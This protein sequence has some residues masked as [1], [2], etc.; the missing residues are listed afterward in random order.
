MMQHAIIGAFVLTFCMS[1]L[2]GI[3]VWGISINVQAF[4]AEHIQRRKQGLPTSALPLSR[5]SLWRASPGVVLSG[6]YVCLSAVFAYYMLS[7]CAFF[8]LKLKSG[9]ES[10]HDLYEQCT[11]REFW[12]G[13]AMWSIP[14]ITALCIFVRSASGLLRRRNAA[15]NAHS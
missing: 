7:E 2:G 12:I 5:R 9:L 6:I 4:S 13:F 3:G 8:L 11:P 1:L 15:L 10:P 14:L